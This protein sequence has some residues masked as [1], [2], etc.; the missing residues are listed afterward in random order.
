MQ[1]EVNRLIRYKQKEHTGFDHQP[2]QINYLPHKL[3]PWKPRGFNAGNATSTSL[4][5]SRYQPL[6]IK[7]R[8]QL[9]RQR[10]IFFF[11]TTQKRAILV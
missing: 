3:S 7:I 4:K 9:I 1:A 2:L 10:R 8:D 6:L 11:K 5:K